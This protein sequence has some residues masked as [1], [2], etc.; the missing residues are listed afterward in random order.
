MRKILWAMAAAAALCGC[1]GPGGRHGAAPE[2]RSVTQFPWGSPIAFA[3]MSFDFHSARNTDAFTNWM[4]QPTHA[5]ANFLI[6]D[7]TM[8]NRTGAPLEPRSQ[9]IFRL[10]DDR[11]T[12]YEPSEAHTAT[13]NLNRPGRLESGAAMAVRKEFV[14]DVPR[15][16]YRLGVVVPDQA[17]VVFAGDVLSRGPYFY[18]ALPG[19]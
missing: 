12:F 8:T 16:H 7:V 9:P 14:F 1:A 13:I 6:V 3:G 19:V 15:G 10:V 4:N 5:D 17:P 11:G 2:R 18:V